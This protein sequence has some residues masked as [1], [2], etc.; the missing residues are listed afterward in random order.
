MSEGFDDWDHQDLQKWIAQGYMDLDDDVA[1]R[2]AADA[3]SCF[4][5]HYDGLQLGW[6]RHPVESEIGIWFPKLFKNNYGVTEYRET[7]KPFGRYLSRP[8]S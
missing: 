8:P 2:I 4:G 7:G 5:K 6:I 1:F 3:A